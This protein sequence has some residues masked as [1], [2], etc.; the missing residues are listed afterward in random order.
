MDHTRWEFVQFTP[1]QMINAGG[2]AELLGPQIIRIIENMKSSSRKS[3]NIMTRMMRTASRLDSR[4]HHDLA[5]G[6]DSMM[7]TALKGKNL[8]KFYALQGLPAPEGG[9]LISSDPR[10]RKHM[11]MVAKDLLK[12]IRAENSPRISDDARKEYAEETIRECAQLDDMGDRMRK[13]ISSRIID[14]VIGDWENQGKGVSHPDVLM[15]IVKE[16]HD[17]I[18]KANLDHLDP[19]IK[20]VKRAIRRY[21]RGSEERKS[22]EIWLSKN[23]DEKRRLEKDDTST[24]FEE[25]KEMIEDGPSDEVLD[26]V[27]S[28]IEDVLFT[29]DGMELVVQ[30]EMGKNEHEWASGFDEIQD[31]HFDIDRLMN[32]LED[33]IYFAES[34]GAGENEFDELASVIDEIVHMSHGGG[35]LLEY[36]EEDDPTGPSSIEIMHRKFGKGFLPYSRDMGFIPKWALESAKRTAESEARERTM[37]QYNLGLEGQGD[38]YY[39]HPR[40]QQGRR[41][42]IEN[43]SPSMRE[44][45]TTDPGEASLINAQ[46]IL[47]DATLRSKDLVNRN[48]AESMRNDEMK[49]WARDDI[50]RQWLERERRKP[51]ERR[52]QGW[53]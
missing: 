19:G 4:G 42:I 7:R 10:G 36:S 9:S 27:S 33:A 40:F 28:F 43:M 22:L 31:H 11:L 30:E 3:Q 16:L 35:P 24:W 18:K 1:S 34:P 46:N 5:D 6:L 26:V 38:D 41:H 17:M 12:R 25:L 20:R 14:D 45:M 48:Y 2:L 15:Q 21:P 47:W 52:D 44:L 51:S 29:K 50:M 37:M 49:D 32:D 53:W 8:A 39:L 13:E 23:M